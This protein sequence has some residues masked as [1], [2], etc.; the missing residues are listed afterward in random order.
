MHQ[1]RNVFAPFAKRRDLDRKNIQSVKK[2]FAKLVVA[3]HALQIAV[4]CGNQAH[5]DTNRSRASQAFKFP[6]LQSAQQL[7]LQFEADVADF[8]EKESAAIRK[9]ETALV[10]A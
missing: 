9:L 8:I 4:R 2:V 5:I 6:F 1:E 7:W 3:N 10:S